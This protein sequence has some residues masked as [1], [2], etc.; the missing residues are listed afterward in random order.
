MKMPFEWDV[1]V[2]SKAS[3]GDRFYFA[4]DTPTGVNVLRDSYTEMMDAVPEPGVTRRY[5][6]TRQG[7]LPVELS[8]RLRNRRGAGGM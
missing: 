5:T 7:C 4:V 2:S 3:R 1:R 6:D 8:T